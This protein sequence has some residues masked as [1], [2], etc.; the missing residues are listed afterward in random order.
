[1]SNHI[2]Q[3][4]AIALAVGVGI[5]AVAVASSVSA[6]QNQ[7]DPQ[8]QVQEQGSGP[9]ISVSE[10]F[11]EKTSKRKNLDQAITDRL[12]FLEDVP[13]QGSRSTRGARSNVIQ[14]CQ[15]KAT[16][17]LR[18]AQN[19]TNKEIRV[20][21]N[22]QGPAGPQG[23]AG[24]QGLPGPGGQALV[25]EDAFGPYLLS[26]QY[27]QSMT[28]TCSRGGTAIGAGWLVGSGSFDFFPLASMQDV[29]SSGRWFLRVQ[30]NNLYSSVE[31]VVS[32]YCLL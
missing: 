31:Y 27:S 30:N 20:S 19:C 5:G 14:A 2:R 15:N 9:D 1:M 17:V 28:L 4:V 12:A 29:D 32:V 7:E 25:Y 3:R 21:W 18:V 23:P 10:W 16:G 13:Q 24:S 8:R 11:Q 26:A 6:D 22:T